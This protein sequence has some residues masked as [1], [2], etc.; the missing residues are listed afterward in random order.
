MKVAILWT[1]L[2]GY[3]N[4]CLRALAEIEGVELFIAYQAPTSDAPFAADQFEWFPKYYRYQSTPEAAELLP[5]MRSF[6]PDVMLVASWHL[7]GFR[8]ICREFR[9][10]SVR[11]CGMEGTLKQWLGVVTSPLY[12]QRMF[13]ATFVAGE[14]QS[15]FARKLGFEQDRIWRG[16]YSCDQP[17]FALTYKDRLLETLSARTFLYIGRLSREKGIDV[18]LEAYKLYRTQQTDP[19]PL[20]IAGEGPLREELERTPGVKLLGFVQPDNL[21]KVFLQAGCFVLPSHWEPWGVVIHEACSTGLPVIC[22]AAC[23]AA[24]H[25]VQDGYSG[26]ITETGDLH[27]LARALRSFTSLTSERRLAMCKASYSLSLQ[28]TPERW[29]N[30]VYDRGSEM[31]KQK[32]LAGTAL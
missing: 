27:S 26:F 4:S 1:K 30:C 23:G 11:V 19:W 2:S 21:P 25:L 17:S 31:L 3:L 24:V 13:D 6:K 12:V 29:A 7:A 14:R 8:A 9:N 18:L 28:F 5:L 16:F 20:I 22:T 15:L 32:K 10:Q